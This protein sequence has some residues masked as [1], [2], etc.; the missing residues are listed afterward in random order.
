MSSMNS[1]HF[2]V[3]YGEA[4]LGSIRNE[5]PELLKVNPVVSGIHIFDDLMTS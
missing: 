3:N 5:I 1:H 2:V 4:M